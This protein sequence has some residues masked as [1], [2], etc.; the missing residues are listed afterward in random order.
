LFRYCIAQEL[1]GEAREIEN[2]TTEINV[3]CSVPD[4]QNKI[5]S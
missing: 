3:Q 5:R 1:R 2:S 4:L